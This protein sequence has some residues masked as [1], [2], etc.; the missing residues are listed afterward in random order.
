MSADAL[1]KITIEHLRGSVIP[2]TL[3]FEKGKKLSVI[4]GENGSGKSTICD[5]FDF[6]GN[7]K[8]GSLEN[9]G[10]GRTN[11]FWHSV[12]KKAKDVSVI[13]ETASNNPQKISTCTATIGTGGVL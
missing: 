9:R 10:L 11:R 1:S 8:V 7:G 12:G 5:A 2:F 13:L 3:P 4:Y 6:I